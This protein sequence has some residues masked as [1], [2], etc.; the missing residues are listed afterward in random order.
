LA[1]NEGWLDVGRAAWAKSH[2]KKKEYPVELSAVTVLELVVVPYVS[3]VGD[4]ASL[5]RVTPIVILPA[6]VANS[7]PK[8]SGLDQRSP[9]FKPMLFLTAK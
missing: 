5:R 9:V 4:R 3:R 2:R 1:S 8:L 7:S 6:K